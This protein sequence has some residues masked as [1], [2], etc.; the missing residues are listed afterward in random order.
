MESS[1]LIILLY[2]VKYLVVRVTKKEM[3]C[4]N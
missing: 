4:L 3:L 1:F 2:F